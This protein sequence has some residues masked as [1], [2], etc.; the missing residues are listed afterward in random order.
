MKLKK[1]NK[2]NK[3]K[4]DDNYNVFKTFENSDKQFKQVFKEFKNVNLKKRFKSINKIIICGMGGSA[5]GPHFVR[6]VFSNKINIPIIIS[7]EYNLPKWVDKNTL[8]VISS[9]SGTTEEPINC[10]KQAKKRNLKI[11]IICTGGDLSKIES[12]K[13]VYNP[14][15]NYAKNP[16]FAIGY[17][18]AS[19]IVL[20]NKLGFLKYN[21]KDIL[22][23]IK[24]FSRGK[25]Q[26]QKIAKEITNKAP[27]I[28]SS[29]HLIGNAH[30][31]QNQINET[32]KNF[33]SYFTIPE[34]C[35]HQLEGLTF[36]KN[37]EKNLVYVLLNSKLYIKRNQKRYEIIKQILKKKKI[38]FVEI[39]TTG[40][41]FFEEAMY[42][43]G[44]SSYTSFYLAHFNKIDPQPNPWVDYLKLK[45]NNS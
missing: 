34:I 30:I 32:G 10:F 26:S 7:N 12:E 24:I 21:T 35:H 20:L 23:Q 6:S 33:A 2:H 8:V 19:F 38:N 36:P 25:L 9:F 43:L 5:L 18:I 22:K 45:M 29:E 40:N 41:N 16:R 44:L 37:L 31:F 15:Y 28:V 27:I 14:K 1:N 11:F 3:V 42:I 39:K 13:F 17:S 4:F